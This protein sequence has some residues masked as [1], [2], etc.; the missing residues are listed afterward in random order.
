MYQSIKMLLIK[1]PHCYALYNR[2]FFHKLTISIVTIPIPISQTQ[3]LKKFP[4]SP[5]EIP[6]EFPFPF[7]ISPYYPLCNPPNSSNTRHSKSFPPTSQHFQKIFTHLIQYPSTS[8]YTTPF[9]TTPKKNLSPLSI[10]PTNS[11]SNDNSMLCNYFYHYQLYN[12]HPPPSSYHHPLA[13]KKNPY[14]QTT[15]RH[16][17]FF[18]VYSP[19]LKRYSKLNSFFIFFFLLFHLATLS[20]NTTSFSFYLFFSCIIAPLSLSLQI[21]KC[22]FLPSF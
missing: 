3:L 20:A 6:L 16:K 21:R 4:T 13:P 14:F 17:I 7:I 10:H 1:E 19:V 8:A 5:K 22:L 2:F 18:F 11:H 12:H 15:T 9:P